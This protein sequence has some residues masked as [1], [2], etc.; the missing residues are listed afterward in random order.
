MSALAGCRKEGV[1]PVSPNGPH[2]HLQLNPSR[3]RRRAGGH[4]LTLDGVTC[5]AAAAETGVTH[6]R[7]AAPFT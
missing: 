7:S 3:L 1:R 6:E 2:A 4:G 5:G